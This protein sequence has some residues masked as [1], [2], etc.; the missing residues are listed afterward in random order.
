LYTAISINDINVVK[1]LLKHHVNIHEDFP[2]HHAVR[3]PN[4][5]NMEMIRLL[6][7]NGSIEDIN[8]VNEIGRTP[9]E[10][11]E[12]IIMVK[13][14]FEYKFA[15]LMTPQVIEQMN[16]NRYYSRR[17]FA[18]MIYK[19]S[20]REASH[21]AKYVPINTFD[22][23][24]NTFNETGFIEAYPSIKGVINNKLNTL[25]EMYTPE[26][27]EP[28]KE[29]FVHKY[30][31]PIID[32]LK[33]MKARKIDIDSISEHPLRFV[34]PEFDELFDDNFK[35]ASNFEFV[36]ANSENILM[37]PIENGNEIAILDNRHRNQRVVI[38]KANGKNTASRNYL[39]KT[40]KNPLTRQPLTLSNINVRTAR[41]QGGRLRHK[42]VKS[43]R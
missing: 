5:K 16:W 30:I 13:G 8:K 38:R 4:A 43:A 33:I 6:L 26:M 28:Q 32:F 36:S 9:F 22:N 12:D 24:V 37:E 11:L 3:L 20:M 18:Q 7:E 27:T 23:Y 34:F 19:D 17:L 29:D 10:L 15:A 41:I 14:Q 35:E 21:L 25:S 39:R 2:L 42:T 1:L 40:K 31:L